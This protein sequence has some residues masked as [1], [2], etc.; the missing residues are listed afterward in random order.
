MVEFVPG[1]C[2]K[3][4][5]AGSASNLSGLRTP[6]LLAV[7]AS[8][9]AENAAKQLGGVLHADLLHDVGPVTLD[10]TCA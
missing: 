1:L 3:M 7:R 5:L 10:G 9:L 6:H 4:N 8:A 2:S